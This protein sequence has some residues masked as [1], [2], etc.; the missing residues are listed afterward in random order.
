MNTPFYFYRIHGLKKKL[1]LKEEDVE[2]EAKKN[3]MFNGVEN[4]MFCKNCK[5]KMVSSVTIKMVKDKRRFE[6][7]LCGDCGKNSE[8]VIEFAYRGCSLKK[9]QV[10][11]ICPTP[12]HSSELPEIHPP[13]PPPPPQSSKKSSKYLGKSLIELANEDDENVEKQSKKH[14]QK[15]S[16][17]LGSTIKMPFAK[18]TSTKIKHNVKT[19][20]RK[21]P[22]EKNMYEARKEK[23]QEFCN[24]SSSSEDEDEK[25]HTKPKEVKRKEAERPKPSKIA[26]KHMS[27][28][29]DSSFSE[30]EEEQRT[31]LVIFRE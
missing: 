26:Y 21:H 10:P 8:G 15:S 3:K 30:S 23:S 12:M 18:P 19:T 27:S 17:Y 24:I 9:T 5:T 6:A 29:H 28:E 1:K 22:I 20:P 2:I 7:E 16:S 25:E 4:K 11:K 31:R 13:P 14:K